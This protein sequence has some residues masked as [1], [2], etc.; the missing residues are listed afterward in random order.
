MVHL[1]VAPS[2]LMTV[3]VPDLLQGVLLLAPPGSH[4]GSLIP[5]PKHG[6]LSECESG[7]K[8]LPQIKLDPGGQLLQ[9][10]RLDAVSAEG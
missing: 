2:W 6:A 8:S 10:D 7:G 5:C 3:N 9:L 4:W 1:S